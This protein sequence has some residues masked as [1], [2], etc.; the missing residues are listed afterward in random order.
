MNVRDESTPSAISRADTQAQDLSSLPL[1]TDHYRST[2][3]WNTRKTT[4]FSRQMVFASRQEKQ[5]DY[6][7]ES[8]V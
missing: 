7:E 3:S 2:C 6:R 1:P 5:H 8:Y 4:A